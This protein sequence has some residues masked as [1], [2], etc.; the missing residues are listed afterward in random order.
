[1]FV[2]SVIAVGV[3]VAVSVWQVASAE[4]VVLAAP[5][6]QFAADA[7]GGIRTVV[8]WGGPVRDA[9]CTVAGA[10]IHFGADDHDAGGGS[11]A[12]A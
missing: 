1:M 11:Y 3:L 7:L 2:R 8:R 6:T 9:R 12:W 10:A 5:I 4:P